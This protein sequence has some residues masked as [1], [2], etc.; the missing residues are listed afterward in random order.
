MRLDTPIGILDGSTNGDGEVI[1]DVDAPSLHTLTAAISHFKDGLGNFQTNALGL[2]WANRVTQLKNQLTS[3][4][5]SH[6]MKIQDCDEAKILKNI[7]DPRIII[8]SPRSI[9]PI[10]RECRFMTI[11]KAELY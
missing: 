10:Y 7:R 1:S 5:K 6:L 9:R 11:D 8:H 4:T 3:L 2:F